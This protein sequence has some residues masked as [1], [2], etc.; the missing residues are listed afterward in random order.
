M[1]V[2]DV[3]QYKSC[4]V[5]QLVAKVTVSDDAI[6]VEASFVVPILGENKSVGIFMY[7][8]SLI[9]SKLEPNMNVTKGAAILNVA[10]LLVVCRN[11]EH[12]H[13]LS[14]VPDLVLRL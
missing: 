14:C 10:V 4:C 12:R 13:S 6:D 5:P 1:K 8:N 7:S 11:G 2:F 3:F 9:T